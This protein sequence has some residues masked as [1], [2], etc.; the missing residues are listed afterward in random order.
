MDEVTPTVVDLQPLRLR[1]PARLMEEQA[2]SSGFQEI[3]VTIQDNTTSGDRSAN[4]YTLR[5]THPATG[6]TYDIIFD[7]VVVSSSFI[8][9]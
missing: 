1:L 3:S 2:S 6:R 7:D 8:Q 9:P 5:G 4:R